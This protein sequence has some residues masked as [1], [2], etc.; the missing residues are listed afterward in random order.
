M[1]EE[2]KRQ[3][4]KDK[5]NLTGHGRNRTLPLSQ[6]DKEVVMIQRIACESV[7]PLHH[8]AIKVGESYLDI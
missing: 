7:Q 2:E 1:R 3:E 6:Q 5:K 8:A 4:I